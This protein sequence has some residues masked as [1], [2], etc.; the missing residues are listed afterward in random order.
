MRPPL[1]LAWRAVP[2]RTVLGGC[3]AALVLASV[4]APRVD[5]AGDTVLLLRGAAVLLASVLAFAV[6]DAAATVLAAS[7][8]SLRRRTAVAVALCAAPVAATWAA[9]VG[10]AV[11]RADGSAVPGLAVEALALGL[12]G[13]ATA[14]GLRAWRGHVEPGVLAAPV[15]LGTLVAVAVLPRSLDMLHPSPDWPGWDGAVERWAVVAAVMAAV[16]VRATRDPA[17]R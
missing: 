6:D 15:V 11:W 17:A 2:R 9:V 4:A 13:L 1:A 16:V 5:D 14:A 8:T 7:P 10:V 3:G 12:I